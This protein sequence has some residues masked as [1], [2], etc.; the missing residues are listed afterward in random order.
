MLQNDFGKLQMMLPESKSV[1]LNNVCQ[2]GN[3]GYWMIL[4]ETAPMAQ[5]HSE[6]M[7]QRS[8]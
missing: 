3:M 1:T 8:L 6:G 2:V 7:N 4:V 5:G